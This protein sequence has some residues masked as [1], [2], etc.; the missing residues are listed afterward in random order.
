MVS[1]QGNTKD[2]LR[3][4]VMAILTYGKM[5]KLKGHQRLTNRRQRRLWKTVDGPFRTVVNKYSRKV[6]ARIEQAILYGVEE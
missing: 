3:R 4:D 6:W 2:E 5:H 1:E